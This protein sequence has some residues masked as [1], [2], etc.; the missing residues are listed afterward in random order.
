LNGNKWRRFLWT[1]LSL[2]LVISV[3]TMA[4]PVAAVDP[5]LAI[6]ISPNVS[7]RL[8]GA[9]FWVNVNVNQ[10]QD[11]NSYKLDVVY[12]PAILQVK[13]AE[14]GAGVTG[15]QIVDYST[16][17][18]TIKN[19]PIT[20]GFNP[21]G[22]PGTIRVTGNLGASF[23]QGAD[24][25]GWLCRINFR[26]VGVAGQTG[27][28]TPVITGS[29][30]GM[31]NTM[32][33]PME[34]LA[35][36]PGTVNVLYPPVTV[37]VGAPANVPAGGTFVARINTSLVAN[38]SGYNFDVIYNP[39]QLQVV[40]TEGGPGVTAGL[41]GS[42]VFPMDMWA[43]QPLH[44]PGK[45]RVLGHIP[46][47]GKVTG[48]GYLAEIQFRVLASSG[49]TTISFAGGG[50]CELYDN[51]GTPITPVTWSGATA[52]VVVPVNITTS[53]LPNA[54]MGIFYSA[55]L[56]AVNGTP[57]YKW[58]ATGLPTGLSISLLG[59]VI[60]GIA[61]EWGDFS[62]NVSV[63]D[64]SNPVMTGS[65][66]LALHVNP[67]LL[68]TTAA[69]PQATAG[70]SYA[71]FAMQ[72]D[73][74]TIPYTW[75]ATGLP[76]GLAITLQG[77]ISGTTTVAPGDYNVNVT[78][79]DT[80]SPAR[81]ANKF[82]VLHVYGGLAITT[83]VLPDAM[84]GSVYAA[85]LTVSGGNGFYIWSA[86]GLPGGLQLST[87]GAITGTATAPGD[88]NVNISVTD[89]FT[90]ANSDSKILVI[91]IYSALQITS[92][93]LPEAAAGS[94]YFYNLQASGGKVSYFWS[95]TGLPTGLNIASSGNIAGA[96]AVFGDFSVNITLIDSFIPANT[97]NT[98][99]SLHV[100]PQ[101]QITT[102]ALP[103][104]VVGKTYTA[105]AGATGGKPTYFF[106]AIGL[107]IGLS[108]DTSGLITGNPGVAGDF[109]VTVTVIDS[110]ATPGT[111]SVSMNLHIYGALQITTTSLAEGL[112][113]AIY[114]TNVT[115]IG[116]KLSYAWS[117]TGLPTGLS[118]A[119]TGVITGTTTE[120]GNFTIVVTVSDAFV[121]SNSTNKTMPLK[122]YL[123]RDANGDGMINMADVVKI[124]RIILGRDAMTPAADA[125]G[126][127]FVNMGDVTKIERVILEIDP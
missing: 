14:G 65:K 119:P 113:G 30:L 116:G 104:G 21:V 10:V 3:F 48:A 72:A 31:W 20:W 43:Y 105:S 94:S 75:S 123:P 54:T 5:A 16:T 24:G 96:P 69:L 95:A 44:T 52:N 97:R 90:P 86:T 46:G 15:G 78:V 29:P 40:G 26:V 92:T 25:T 82:L 109:S 32:N 101:L 22:A 45:I 28:I 9:E 118:M 56:T 73:G 106:S 77:I 88:F 124:E 100:Y 12:D 23:F 19:I 80:S 35:A 102:S 7:S 11:L 108:M 81:T 6:S 66:T 57:S 98:V 63:N 107:P 49:S 125:N 17:P 42:T 27:A 85:S 1:G 114:F 110:L 70:I 112:K 51:I 87:A 117:A 62:V 47:N 8:T 37:S 76:T 55:N 79:T 50:V 99:L 67:P 58:S 74:G 38:L 36:I 33:G 127:G 68:I 89:T 126:D 61:E 111:K 122:I 120:I 13:G 121:P 115:A 60:S 103:E 39:A 93:A 71:P 53:S 2:G 4:T 59:G 41:V 64:S 18:A 34:V 91:H 83:T 84:L